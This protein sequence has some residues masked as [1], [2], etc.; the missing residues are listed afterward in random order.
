M[1]YV[2]MFNMVVVGDD[3]D[4]DED[5]VDSVDDD[6]FDDEDEYELD[7]VNFVGIGWL[8]LLIGMFVNE[9]MSMMGLV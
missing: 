8:F 1:V 9:L 5:D 6:Y 7:N 3:F 2:D 4:F